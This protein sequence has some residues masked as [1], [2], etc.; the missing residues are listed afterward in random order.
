LP[1]TTS[2]PGHTQGFFHEGGKLVDTPDRVASGLTQCSTFPGLAK[3]ARCN[4][5]W[6]CSK[7]IEQSQ[8]SAAHV[9]TAYFEEWV[10]QLAD[11]ARIECEKMVR[12]RGFEEESA[13]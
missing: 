2:S 11:I 8:G 1:F 3:F 5:Y 12:L 6:G 9:D 7:N 4:A 10:E 13:N